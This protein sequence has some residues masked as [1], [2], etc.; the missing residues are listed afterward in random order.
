MGKPSILVAEDEG[1]VAQD[2]EETLTDLGYTVSAVVFSGEE[3]IEKAGEIR[4][5]LILMDIKL[6]GK[7]H[8]VAAAEQIRARFDIPVVYLTAYADD[9]T[10]S[11]AKVT[12]PFGYIVKPFERRELHSVIQMA[13][14][15]HEMEQK[16]RKSEA[17]FRALVEQA[18]DLTLILDKE[19][20]ILR[21]A[22]SSVVRVLG[23]KPV[24]VVGK[25]LLEFVHPND[26][27]EVRRVLNRAFQNPRLPIHTEYRL[28]HKDGSFRF[29]E[30][31]AKN[32][33]DDPAVGGVVV[34][35]RDISERKQ[36]ELAL[37]E[38]RQHCRAALDAMD[39]LVYV[40]DRDLCILLFNEAFRK[41]SVEV[42]V[43]DELIGKNLFEVFS[44]LPDKAR[45][46]YRLALRTGEPVLVEEPQE[47]G[48]MTTWNYARKIP[49]LDEEGA[50]YQIVVVT[51]GSLR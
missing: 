32:L 3:A 38:S 20:G 46:E 7:M 14:Y 45:E 12:E 28:R 8:G 49:L 43:G 34:N 18:S 27:L 41:L 11:Y 29:F 19:E 4:P 47:I 40:V 16:L 17:R 30:I 10:L 33:D 13:L 23:Y 2:V 24:D 21:Y 31:I 6:K 48:G 37:W 5:D 39:E 1:V 26:V 51:S 15:K 42:G 36:A 22:S 35:G 9:Q 25:G 50:V 44:F